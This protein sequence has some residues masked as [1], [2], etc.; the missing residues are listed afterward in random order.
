MIRKLIGKTSFLCAAVAITVVLVA[1]AWVVT[2]R[3]SEYE[4]EQITETVETQPTETTES[5]ENPIE[6]KVKELVSDIRN[7]NV[8]E[9]A[10]NF[11]RGTEETA[12]EPVQIAQETQTKV[13]DT[14]SEEI[15][16]TGSQDTD[17]EELRQESGRIAGRSGLFSDSSESSDD[18]AASVLHRQSTAYTSE[19]QPEMTK[20]MA[21]RRSVVHEREAYDEAKGKVDQ[22]LRDLGY[23]E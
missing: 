7:P 17:I 23:V 22:M 20:N 12:S 18:T 10:E 15:Y 21:A 3:L 5:E 11:V 4:S 19:T 8:V 2:S 13:T 16:D 6:T 1:V 14:K 9:A